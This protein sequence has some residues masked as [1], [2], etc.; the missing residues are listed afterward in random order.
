MDKLT[1][2]RIPEILERLEA[3]SGMD[4]TC[5]G[6]CIYDLVKQLADTMRENERLWIA[7]KQAADNRGDQGAVLE[8]LMGILSD[9]QHKDSENGR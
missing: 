8:P 9:Y 2:D 1:I 5:D 6:V 7:I 4:I 3:E